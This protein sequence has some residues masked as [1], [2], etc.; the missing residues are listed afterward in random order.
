[1]A[2]TYSATIR[3]EVRKSD[4]ELTIFGDK[5][6]VRLLD[7]Y[8]TARIAGLNKAVSDGISNIVEVIQYD[9]ATGKS[10]D[11]KNI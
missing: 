6:S 7:S 9:D 2:V 10:F 1:M 8:L 11:S 3:V 5:E 4:I